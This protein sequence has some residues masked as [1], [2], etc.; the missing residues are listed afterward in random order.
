[1]ASTERVKWG[2]IWRPDGS[3]IQS[4]FSDQQS[5]GA[6]SREEDDDAVVVVVVLAREVS[7]KEEV[8]GLEGVWGKI[9]RHG[10]RQLFGSI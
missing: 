2:A 9:V 5:I 10:S 6:I 3:W 4:R 7:W 8:I 1:M